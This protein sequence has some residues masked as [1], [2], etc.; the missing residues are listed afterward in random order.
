MSERKVR[1]DAKLKLLPATV[2]EQLA[3]VCN[4]PGGTLEKARTWLK[5]EHGVA[6]SV[7]TISEWLAWYQMKRV[8]A[9]RE[10]KVEAWLECERLEHPE[11]TD[12][13][14][15]RRGQRKFSLLAIA[16]ENPEEWAR[17]QALGLERDRRDE[18]KKTA[19]EKALDALAAEVRNNAQAQA[20]LEALTQALREAARS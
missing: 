9:L 14:L 19:R 11:L 1:A 4:E 3:Q 8:A 13:E 6:V 20:A 10:A 7:N 5:Q 17:V 16:E 15:F 2:Q 12:E 18:Q